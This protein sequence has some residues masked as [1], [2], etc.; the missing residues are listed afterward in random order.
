MSRSANKDKY[1]PE[2]LAQWHAEYLKQGYTEAELSAQAVE[3]FGDDPPAFARYEAAF[4]RERGIG[5]APPPSAPLSPSTSGSFRKPTAT[6]LSPASG[7]HTTPSPAAS[8]APSG[9][10]YRPPAA[11]SEP[12]WT[13]QYSSQSSASVPMASHSSASV[14]MDY[15]Q[16]PATDYRNA[17]AASSSSEL[18]ESTGAYTEEYTVRSATS[19]SARGL[20]ASFAVIGAYVA[21][22]GV[23]AA[24]G[25]RALPDLPTYVPGWHISTP[26]E[27]KYRAT[28]DS[29]L[30]FDRLTRAYVEQY[31][32]LPT[33]I[34]QLRR[35]RQTVP[36]HDGWDEEFVLKD[37]R[38]ISGGSDGSIGSPDD[39]FL[40]AASGLIANGS[41][42]EWV[43]DT[44]HMI[45]AS[46]GDED[47]I[48]E[49]LLASGMTEED[50][51]YAEERGPSATGELF[52]AVM[53]VDAQDLERQRAIQSADMQRYR[54]VDAHLQ[55]NRDFMKQMAED[56][57]R[58]AEAQKASGK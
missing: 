45:R 3:Y 23:L 2:Y 55:E 31:G 47:R 42:D 37:G 4:R 54:E 19:G 35:L 32:S 8:S 21:T 51:A 49:L 5:A 12:A 48:N 41:G 25:T 53:G 15:R 39:V 30:E 57:R 38:Y 14:P 27:P 34:N 13:N 33:G 58:A 43:L 20:V 36:L 18:D 52:Y 1:D 46:G 28:R 9:A 44:T 22:F 40:F 56:R 29:L 26:E 10:A 50:L 6:P 24:A 7:V 11:A 17:S 16:T